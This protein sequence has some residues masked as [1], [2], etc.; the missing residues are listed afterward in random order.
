MRVAIDARKLHDFG[1]GTYIRN[2]LRQLAR[3]DHDTDYVLLSSPTDLDVAAQLGPNFR[4]VLEPSPN[5]S[6]REQI[7]VPWVLHRERP[8]VFHAPHYV[9][10]PAI[11]CRSVV[12]IH[13]CIHLMFP[14]YLPN[15]AAYAYAR[16][17]MWAAVKRSSRILTVSEASKRDI[18]HF[19]NVAP[20][21]IKV[22]YNAID[23]HFWLT[24]PE[25]EV[26]RVRE[27]YQLDHQFVLYVGNIKPHKNLV[28]LIDAFD[29]LR[30]T[31]LED[32]KLLI[33]G[34]EISKLPAL[35][36]AVHRHK[37]HKHVRFLGF[38]SDGTLRILYRLAS[39]FVFPSLY[40]GFGLPPLEAMASGTPVVTSNQ[41][42]LP[43]VTGDA[44]V[45]V[46]P[47]D[48]DSLVD[49]IRRVLTDPALAAELRRR[50]PE[51]AREFSWAHSVE[52]TRR[53]YEAVGLR[54]TVP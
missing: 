37:L 2:L 46:D 51:R 7:H 20:E 11:R 33:I 43:E 32:L 10:P 29:E 27:R 26:A 38:V 52:K 54:R 14:Q 44:A 23:D 28:R 6:L 19:F 17:S 15:K 42:S 47:Y 41:S 22:V 9:L 18:L 13:D 16:A 45:L 4:S 40:E 39:V 35:R 25:E 24:P 3:I 8:D 34:D 53:V 36:R 50:G 49:G 1:I 21:K 30:R 12:T 31:G 5:Y 48:V